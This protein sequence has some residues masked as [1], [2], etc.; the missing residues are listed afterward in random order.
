MA[1]ERV[2]EIYEQV[3]KSLPAAEQIRLVEKIAHNLADVRVGEERHDRRSWR[4]IRGIVR[5]PLCGEDAQEWVSRTRREADEHR[6]KQ[7]RREP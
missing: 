6:E 2:E 4:E 1:S 7:W 3:V 5:Y